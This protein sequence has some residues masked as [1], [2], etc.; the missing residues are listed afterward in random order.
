VYKKHRDGLFNQ[1]KICNR[2]EN[3]IRKRKN[4]DILS[5][6]KKIWYQN[7]KD[8]VKASNSRWLARNKESQ[9]E[10]RKKWY[11]DNSASVLE[12]TKKYAKEN[13]DRRRVILQRYKARKLNVPNTLTPEQWI[14]IKLY[15]DDKCAYCG[16]LEPLA[17]D[18]FV[19]VSKGGEYTHNNI[20][21]ACQR[22]NSSKGSQMAMTWYKSQSYY[23]KSR[24]SRILSHLGYK[25][26]VQQL[27]LA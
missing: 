14:D 21:P 7:N 18:H 16:R 23:S 20:I 1:C 6:K 22:C 5:A 2:K 3:I 4:K 27:S 8:S 19:A 15:F 25:G 24:E 10:Y 17:Q 13:P 9:V 11:I 26:N 12:R